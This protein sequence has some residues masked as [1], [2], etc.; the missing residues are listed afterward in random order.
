M[1]IAVK[2]PNNMR[3]QEKEFVR[4]QGRLDLPK[5]QLHPTATPRAEEV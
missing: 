5:K 3:T 4:L 1:E 2:I